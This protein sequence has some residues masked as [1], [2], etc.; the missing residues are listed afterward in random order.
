M[1]NSVWKGRSGKFSVEFM[2]LGQKVFESCPST[3]WKMHFNLPNQFYMFQI[4]QLAERILFLFALD[5]AQFF[6]SICLDD[7]LLPSLKPCAWV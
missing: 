5:L 2:S 4:F 6:F 7:G 3:C 1:L